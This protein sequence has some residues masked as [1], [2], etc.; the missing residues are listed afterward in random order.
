M[1]IRNFIFLLILFPFIGFSQGN[2]GIGTTDP[3]REKLEVNGIIFTSGNGGIRFPDGS[4][5]TTAASNMTQTSSAPG[6]LVLQMTG[7]GGPVCGSG[8]ASGSPLLADGFNILSTSVGASSPA[9]AIGGG[10]TGTPSTT[11]FSNVS[12]TR[13]SDE[14]SSQIQQYLVYS[15]VIPEIEIFYLTTGGAEIYYQQVE[16]YTD[17]IITSYQTGMSAG[18]GVRTESISF[19]YVKKRAYAYM[20]NTRFPFITYSWDRTPAPAV[21]K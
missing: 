11:S 19:D 18:E 21:N 2:V 14:F 4:L 7:F 1:N 20:E 12:L 10:G 6:A 13:F 15:T 8:C 3:P 5:Q 17:C 16:V 9:S